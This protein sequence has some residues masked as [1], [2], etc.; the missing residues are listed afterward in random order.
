MVLNGI[1]N[2]DMAGIEAEI[3]GADEELSRDEHLF[4][5]RLAHAA[6]SDRDVSTICESLSVLRISAI[7]LSN[8]YSNL[9]DE[10]EGV[11]IACRNQLPSEKSV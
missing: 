9:A 7:N 10:I 1:P 2:S 3:I 8:I 5:T 4:A 11:V 6:M